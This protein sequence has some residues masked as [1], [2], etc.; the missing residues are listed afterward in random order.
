MHSKKALIGKHKKLATKIQMIS[1]KER[2]AENF[3]SVY[4]EI[5]KN[6][7]SRSSVMK[8]ASQDLPVSLVADVLDVHPNTVRKARR[9]TKNVFFMKNQVWSLSYKIRLTL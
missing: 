4:H 3:K 5:P 2:M 9:T 8:I 7:S 6:Y 1:T